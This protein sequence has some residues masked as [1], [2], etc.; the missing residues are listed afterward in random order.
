[1][2]LHAGELD[3]EALAGMMSLAAVTFTS[4][5]FAIALSQAVGTPVIAVFGAHEVVALLCLRQ[6]LRADLG[7]RPGHAVRT[8]FARVRVRQAHRHRRPATARIARFVES[9]CGIPA[10]LP[11]V[12]A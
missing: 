10:D 7:H 3:T 5:G 9:H 12:V 4:P 1:M 6:P 8:L 11:A 2:T